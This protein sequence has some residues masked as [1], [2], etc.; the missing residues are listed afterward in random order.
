[1]R[2]LL[3]QIKELLDAAAWCIKLAW[4]AS[5]F[6]TIVRLTC[7][8][9]LPITTILASYLGRDVLDSLVSGSY[10]VKM[11]TR[12]VIML[13]VVL[14]LISLSKSLL[15]N[16][17]SY[18]QTMHEAKLD[19]RLSILMMDRTISADIEFFDK[20]E[21]YDQIT[22]ANRDSYAAKHLLWNT[23]SIVSGIV[24]FSFVFTALSSA[25]FIYGLAMLM[26]AI[27]SSIAAK[28]YTKSMYSLTVDQMRKER[29]MNYCQSIT[30]DRAYAQDIRLLSFG[31]KIKERYTRIWG[32]LFTQRRGITRE[33]AVI[34]GVLESFPEIVIAICGMDI[35]MQIIRA[36]ET[37]GA[38]AL[39]T[40]LLVQLW[41]SILIVSSSIVQIYDNKM[42]IDS[43]RN[44]QRYKNR[45][46]DE[47]ARKLDSV[48]SIELK[49]VS[50]TYPGAKVKALDNICLRMDKTKRVAIVGLNGSGKSTL[51]KLLLRLYEPDSGTICVNG[52][53]IREY[54]LLEL[55]KNFSVYFQTMYNLW[56][57]LRD[58]FL[59]MNNENDDSDDRIRN[60]L[61]ACQCDDILALASHYLDTSLS[62]CFDPEGIELSGGQ[63]QKLALAR[64]LYRRH[65]V[66]LLD[67]PSSSLDP[68]AEHDIFI[69]LDQ[70]TKDKLTVFTSHRLTCISLSDRVV[71]LEKGHILEDGTPED[72]IAANG[73]FAEL[74][75]YQQA[76]RQHSVEEAE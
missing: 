16:A 7:E 55:R 69:A 59:Y 47:G 66:L 29:Q 1:M 36:R 32:E 75:R 54:Q 6:Y 57:S 72:L 70:I 56:F 43:I 38:Y 62:K 63:H 60:S 23:I 10:D 28:R 53:N 22:I 34:T 65:T 3:K 39:Y 31:E 41:S 71:V 9:A 76:N 49:N 20:P 21:Y 48:E 18:C 40:G 19:Y 11:K 58:N 50:F 30:M 5:S 61:S 4:K 73:R 15:R 2:K 26:A 68:K 74:Y 45:V 67:E 13:L 37:I 17:D 27:P 35:S 52:I 42:K 44:I 8:T 12:V 46:M 25:N 24:S 64:A 33:R 51:V 14:L